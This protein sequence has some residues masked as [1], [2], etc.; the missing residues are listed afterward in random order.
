MI[1]RK[2]VISERSEN[3]KRGRETERI[4]ERGVERKDSKIGQR[5]KKWKQER[6]R[7]R[8]GV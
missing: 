1:K 6:W 8:G 3:Q 7:E 4:I 5:A 2:G